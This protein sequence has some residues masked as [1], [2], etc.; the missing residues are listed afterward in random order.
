MA[1][2][3]RTRLRGSYR[4]T[5]F[6]A[7]RLSSLQCVPIQTESGILYADL[8]ITSSHGI[9]A[10]P[11]SDSGEDLVMRKFVKPGNTVFDIGAHLGLYTLLLSELVGEKGI[12]F[13]FEPNPELLPQYRKNDWRIE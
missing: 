3:Y 1:N 6:L 8:R 4:L 13:A 7:Q 2:Y 5:N 12:V 9:L 10:N 11:K